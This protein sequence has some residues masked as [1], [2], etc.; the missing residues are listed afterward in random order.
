MK[1][2]PFKGHNIVMGKNQP[3]YQP[4]P[5]FKNNSDAGEIIT[6]WRLSLWER[7]RILFTGELWLMLMTFNHPVQ[8]VLLTTYQEEIFVKNKKQI[9][10][11][12][13]AS[14]EGPG[15]TAN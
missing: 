13:S 12:D 15:Q 5:A 11:P 9:V 2:K 10:E 1:P 6:C 8:P 14:E 4:L 7:I 3:E